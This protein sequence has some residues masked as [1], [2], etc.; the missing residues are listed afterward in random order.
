VLIALP[1]AF[2][3]VLGVAWRLPGR[4]G[5]REVVGVAAFAL[6]VRLAATFVVS[7]IADQAHVTKVWLNDEASFFLAT[8]ALDANPLGSQ[9]PPGLDHLGG[10]GYLGVTTWL[11]VIGGGVADANTFRVVNSALGA[12][13]VVLAMLMARRIFGM[14]AA[15]LA[16]LALA[17]WPTLVLWSA[18]ML[19]DTLGGFVVMVAAWTLGRAPELGRLR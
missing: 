3:A 6:A 9:L 4:E 16:G 17:V 1:L 11:S 7:T 8:Q 14:R 2:I 18:T 19:R 10:D 13:G 12:L 5:R 15:L